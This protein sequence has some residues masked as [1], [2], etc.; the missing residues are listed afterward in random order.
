MFRQVFLLPKSSKIY[1]LVSSIVLHCILYYFIAPIAGHYGAITFYIIPL[2]LASFLQEVWV[3]IFTL[4]LSLFINF[5]LYIFIFDKD[6]HQVHV[7][8]IEDGGW[9]RLIAAILLSWVSFE[10]ISVY[11]SL[12]ESQQQ[13]TELNEKLEVRVSER[14]LELEQTNA[15]L[16]SEYKF[17]REL[18]QLKERLRAKIAGDTS[19]HVSNQVS[20]LIHSINNSLTIIQGSF[21]IFTQRNPQFQNNKGTEKIFEHTKAIYSHLGEMKHYLSLVQL[22]IE[23]V[24][25]LSFCANIQQIAKSKELSIEMTTIDED[26]ILVAEVDILLKGLMYLFQY[27]QIQSSVE[28][29]L[30]MAILRRGKETLLQIFYGEE[31]RFQG[32]IPDLIVDILQ[33]QNLTIV[34]QQEKYLIEIVYSA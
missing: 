14:T 13:Y 26:A 10:F 16:E 9:V 2:I 3:S 33:L 8:F 29:V 15:T 7:I 34:H 28:V 5:A 31:N 25:I 27:I 12:L 32:P 20:T 1:L 17:N 22:Q 21:E 6:V 11:N 19:K 30:Q 18:F 23:P 4:V 24:E